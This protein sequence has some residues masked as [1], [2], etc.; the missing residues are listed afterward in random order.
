MCAVL[1]CTFVNLAAPAAPTHHPARHASFSIDAKTPP[2]AAAAAAPPL[3]RGRPDS[4]ATRGEAP[5]HRR[6]AESSSRPA[7][8]CCAPARCSCF[9]QFA[10]LLCARARARPP[11]V[12]CRRGA[13]PHSSRTLRRCPVIVPAR[14]PIYLLNLPSALQATTP[15]AAPTPPKIKTWTAPSR[16]WGRVGCEPCAARCLPWRAHAAP[17]PA[18]VRV[19]ACAAREEAPRQTGQLFP[20]PVQAAPLPANTCNMDA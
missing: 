5:P 7:P 10:S 20:R 9:R 2:G 17:R 11:F 15:A 16:R 19:T 6:R 4:R 18:G 8:A 13:G 14:A 3:F 12:S 1:F